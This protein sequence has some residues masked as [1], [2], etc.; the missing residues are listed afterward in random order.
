MERC[1]R[2][3]EVAGEALR[4]RLGVGRAPDDDLG[5]GHVQGAKNI[6]PWMWSRCKWVSRMS[7]RRALAASLSPR[8]RMPEPASST[9]SLPSESVTWR[10]E[11]LPP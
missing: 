5:V 7:I 8:L 3:R 9:R 2:R 11:V 10:Q 6:S 4:Q 1:E